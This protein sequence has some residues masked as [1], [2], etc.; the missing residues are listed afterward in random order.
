LCFSLSSADENHLDRV[1]YASALS[2]YNG[3]IQ[4]NA[5]AIVHLGAPMPDILHPDV[6]GK[7]HPTFA[8]PP[9][10]NINRTIEYFWGLT[11]DSAFGLNVSSVLIQNFM[12]E[13]TRFCL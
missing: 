3:V 2:F 10:L 6:L 4:K 7:V 1:H 5:Y 13:G 9:G 11:S 12:N 8:R